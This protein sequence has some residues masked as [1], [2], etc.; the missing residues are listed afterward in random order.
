MT[1]QKLASV[2]V[3]SVYNCINQL[4]TWI[5]EHYFLH[6]TLNN[7]VLLFSSNYQETFLLL[8]YKDPGPMNRNAMNTYILIQYTVNVVVGGKKT[9]N[10][11]LFY[12]KEYSS[13][14]W[15]TYYS[16][17][18]YTV[19]MYSTYTSGRLNFQNLVVILQRPPEQYSTIF[20]STR[21]EDCHNSIAVAW[22]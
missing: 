3:I 1:Q 14:R 7:T 19:H 10:L 15:I 2:Q 13:K 8:K 17:V 4:V 5:F 18:Q 22:Y 12:Q 11:E 16:T 20:H 6:R 9:V 21:V